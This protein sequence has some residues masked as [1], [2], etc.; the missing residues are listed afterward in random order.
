MTEQHFLWPRPNRVRALRSVFKTCTVSMVETRLRA[1]FGGGVPV[2][3]SSARAALA[4]ALMVRG[5]SRGDYVGV[6]PFAS[7]CVLD[8]VARIA[9]PTQLTGRSALKLVFQQWGFIRHIGLSPLDIEDC[10]DSLLAESGQLFSGGGGIEIWSLPKIVG[11]TSGGVLW[12]QNNDTAAAVRHSRD[13][14]TS[15]I[16][17]LS[18][19]RMLGRRSTLFHSLWQGAEP[20]RGKPTRWQACEIMHALD[21]W[22]ETVRARRTNLD[23]AWQLAPRWV[24]YPTDRFPCVVPVELQEGVDGESLA[25]ELK[26]AA[27]L[28]VFERRFST[29]EHALVRVLPIPIHQDMDEFRLRQVIKGVQPFVKGRL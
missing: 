4:H 15:G 23:I 20:S 22:D 21:E 2:L 3:F 13:A 19:L 17:L 9:T 24:H 1:M 29:K 18:V 6:F 10:A 28:R 8:V 14:E 12:C 26:L 27:G 7:H 25:S 16:L 11:T 5:L